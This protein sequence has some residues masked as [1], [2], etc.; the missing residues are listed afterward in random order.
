M[1]PFNRPRQPGASLA[2]HQTPR[3]TG[4]EPIPDAFRQ[5][6]A[7]PFA[8]DL[9][10]VLPADEVAEIAA[11]GS[12]AFHCVGDTGGVKDPEPQKLVARGLEESLKGPQIAPSLRG[13]QMSPSF[14]YHLGDVVYYNGEVSKYYDQFYEPYEHYPLPIMGIPGNHDG[15]PADE[16]ATTLEGFYQNFLAEG[17][18]A[19]YTHESHDSGRPAMHQPFFYWTLTTPFATFIGLYSNVPEHGR[20][21]DQ[22]RAWFQESMKA[23]D[24][25]KALVVAVHHPIYSFDTYHSGS[26]TM[27]KELEDAINASGRVPNLVL[28]AHVHNYQRIELQAAGHTIPFLVIGNG[29]YWNLHHLGAAPGYKDPETEAELMAGIDSRHGFMTFEISDRVING[30]FTTVPRPQESWSDAQAYS[31]TFDVFS[32]DARPRTLAEGERITLV[33]ADGSNVPPHTDHAT[34]SPPPRSGASLAR[35][36]ARSAHA[37]RTS[38]R[39]AHAG[40]ATDAAAAGRTEPAGG[41]AADAGRRLPEP[42]SADVPA[43]AGGDAS[44]GL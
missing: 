35:S 31:A 33:P 14:L 25:G 4:Y 28:S 40:V 24:A 38:R 41:S 22:Q 30:H 7:P 16:Q 29:G 44:G 13:A 43:S 15:E 1:P 19:V 18:G 2:H 21:D 3:I 23:A 39:L 9:S 17:G 20:I 5:G 11:A 34:T 42:G 37:A 12:M 26:A 8:M 10:D 32:Y 36:G 27:A 6:R